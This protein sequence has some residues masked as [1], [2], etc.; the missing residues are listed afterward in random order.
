[1][2]LMVGKNG[3]AYVLVKPKK[4]GDPEEMKAVIDAYFAWADKKKNPYTV[5]G[6]SLALG[7]KSSKTIFKYEKEEGYEQFH[8][9]VQMAKLQIQN[10][11]VEKLVRGGNNQAGLIFLLANNSS[12]DYKRDPALVNI[13][14]RMIQLDGFKLVPPDEQKKELNSDKTNRKAK[15]SLGK[16]AR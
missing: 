13:D 1:M 12:D 5:E 3:R 2:T 4:Y 8:D 6:L 9:M 16:A 7:F 14:N 11:R 10:Q 15:S